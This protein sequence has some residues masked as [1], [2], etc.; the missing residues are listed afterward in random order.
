MKRPF[1]TNAAIDCIEPE[2]VEWKS[3]TSLQQQ[4]DCPDRSEHGAASHP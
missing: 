3:R 2:A 4:T 1:M